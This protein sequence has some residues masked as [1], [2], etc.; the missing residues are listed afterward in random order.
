MAEF[1]F[2]TEVFLRSP[3][4]TIP[5]M[6][7]KNNAENC[8]KAR[9]KDGELECEK[10]CKSSLDTLDEIVKRKQEFYIK[11]GVEYC[12]HDCWDANNLADCTQRCIKEY[13]T[14]FS[15]FRD[16]LLDRLNS[17]KLKE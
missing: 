13:N 16:T 9:C 3:E 15:D 7:L 4:W 12:K 10:S 17:T 11:K 8:I 1:Y 2:D 6:N 14:L 5:Y